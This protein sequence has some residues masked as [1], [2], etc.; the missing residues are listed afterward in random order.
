MSGPPPR[1]QRSPALAMAAS[2]HTTAEIALKRVAA[3]REIEE[4]A[5]RAVKEELARVTAMV[6]RLER[7]AKEPLPAEL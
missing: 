7:M 3:V 6:E 1:R 5:V 4:G 2:V